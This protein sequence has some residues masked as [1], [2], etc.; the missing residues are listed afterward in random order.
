MHCPF[1][2]ATDSRVLDSRL[3]VEGSAVRRRRVCPECGERFT[4]MEQ[5]QL[6]LPVI[7]KSDGSREAFSENKLRK[8]LT[9]ALHNRPVSTE[10]VETAITHILRYARLA[11]DG[12]VESRRMG[13]WVMDEL[14]RLDQVA[15]VRFASVY[16]RFEDV[17]E[18]REE[19]ERLEQ[20]LDPAAREI[21]LSLLKEPLNNR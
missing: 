5:A 1:C 6:R 7:V 15:Y 19:I 2:N 16:R 14:K 11:A 4:T 10:Q 13:E 8:S 9:T 20:E 3:V 17:Q 18:F 12:E 21:Q